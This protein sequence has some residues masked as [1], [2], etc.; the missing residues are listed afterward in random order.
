MKDDMKHFDF[1]YKFGLNILQ[2]E[3]NINNRILSGQG[4]FYYGSIDNIGGLVYY[5]DFLCV[6]EIPDDATVVNLDEYYIPCFRTDK[7]ILTDE[8]YRF[9]ND[10]DVNFLISIDPDLKGYLNDSCFIR[11]GR[12]IIE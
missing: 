7:I 6:V 1:Q 10:D 12:N 11:N 2:Q 4:G 9:D 8:I 3:L 5:G